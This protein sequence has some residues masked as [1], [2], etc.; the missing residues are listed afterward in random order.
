MQVLL[1]DIARYMPAITNLMREH[2][3]EAGYSF[4]FKPNIAAYIRLQERG[5]M[6]AYAAVIDGEVIG[7]CTATVS[8][9]LHNPEVISCMSD[10]LFVSKK[11][12]N[13]SAGGRLILAIE[14]EAKR[15]GATQIQ[16]GAKPGSTLQ[17]TLAK[18]NY[19][20]SDVMMQKEL[21]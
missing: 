14:A 7:Y 17:R 8:R 19:N 20:A 1:A 13:T 15:R 3:N 5:N 6:F 9:E 12:R 4:E 10:A 21:I 2:W 11:Y 16:W 18:R